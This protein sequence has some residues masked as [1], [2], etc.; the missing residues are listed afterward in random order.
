MYLQLLVVAERNGIML[1]D[2]STIAQNVVLST[3]EHG[4]ATLTYVVPM[5][6]VDALMWYDRAGTP[7]AEIHSCTGLVWQGRIE[8]VSL[9]R[10]GIRV[11][12]LGA[13]SAFADV[14]YTGIFSDASRSRWRALTESDAIAG[15]YEQR[16]QTDMQDRLYITPRKG[17]QYETGI[18]G[19]FG[20]TPME[21]SVRPIIALSFDYEAALPSGW[22]VRAQR[23]DD[24]WGLLS[25]EWTLLGT[26]PLDTGTQTLSFT[27]CDRL[28]FAFEYDATLATYSGATGDVYLKITNIRVQT[29]TTAATDDITRAFIA[30]VGSINPG[31]LNTAGIGIQSP[32]LDFLDESYTDANMQSALTRLARLGD[33]QTPPRQW[34]VGVWND[35]MVH[36][37]PRGSAAQTWYVDASDLEVERSLSQVF[38]SVYARFDG[39]KQITATASSAISIQRHGLTRTAVRASQTPDE[40]QAE[41]ERDAYLNDRAEPVPRA[42]VPIVAVYDAT[43][44]RWPLFLVRS[45][46]VVILRNLPLGFDA[47]QDRIASFRISETR[48]QC[49][50]DTLDITPESPLNTLDVLIARSLEVP[51]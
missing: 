33:N 49:D 3:N 26:G 21:G 11:A 51:A 18:F 36:L 2:W 5:T 44:Y 25:T 41:S 4:Y 16:W 37:R 28:S 7:W 38:N 24:T 47:S 19:F 50:T 27:G 45:G 1:A 15:A 30:Y 42:S 20:Y 6:S 29:S 43:G 46:D 14:P 48:Y 8:D 10:E 13:W 32:G 22:T 34:E 9:V 17:E 40:T 35:G 12:A 23:R 31:Q 39:G